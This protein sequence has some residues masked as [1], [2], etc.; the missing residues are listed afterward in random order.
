MC[1]CKKKQQVSEKPPVKIS[2]SEQTIQNGVQLTPEQQMVA[3][4]IVNRILREKNK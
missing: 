1:G 3:N 4:K 2:V